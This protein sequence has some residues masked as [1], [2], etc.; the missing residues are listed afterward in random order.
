VAE[1][2]SFVHSLRHGNVIIQAKYAGV[3][4]GEHTNGVLVRVEI[5]VRPH[6]TERYP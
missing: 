4:R 1:D 6:R 5:E 2:D 3:R